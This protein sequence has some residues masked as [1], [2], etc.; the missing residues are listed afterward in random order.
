M[1]S[2]KL[3]RLTINIASP[4]ETLVLEKEYVTTMERKIA[5]GA[6]HIKGR[7]RKLGRYSASE[8]YKMITPGLPWGLPAAKYF[9]IEDTNEE[10]AFRMLKGIINHEQVQRFLA[11]EKNEVKKEYTYG[12]FTLVGKADHLPDEDTV[13]EIKTSEKAMAKSKPWQDH[14]TKLYCSMFERSKGYIL[15]P[16]VED[17]HLILK[18]VGCV[19]RDDVWFEQEMQKLLNYHERLEMLD[20]E[21]QHASGQ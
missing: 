8:I 16:I 13:W 15:Q 1:P 11:S 10:S 18:E 12:P 2:G 20:N 21:I 3:E 7:K 4:E 17:G 19:E 14:Q 5:S 9:D 6:L